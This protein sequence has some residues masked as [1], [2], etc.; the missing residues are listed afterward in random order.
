MWH[1]EPYGMVNKSLTL[2]KRFERVKLTNPGANTPREA[3]TKMK[4]KKMSPDALLLLSATITL[5]ACAA[6]VLGY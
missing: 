2:S 4:G 6:K 1:I 5:V 3:G